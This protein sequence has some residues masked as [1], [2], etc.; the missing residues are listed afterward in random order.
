MM[1]KR[2][3]WT[4]AIV[5]ALPLLA[6]GFDRFHNIR[7]VGSTDLE[8]AFAITDAATGDPLPGAKVEVQSEGGFYEERDRQE[9]VLTAGADGLAR[10]ACRRS[11]CFGTQSGLW[12]T[13]TFAVHLPW[14]RFRPVADGYEPAEWTDLDVPE[15][16]RQAKKT[17]S[18]AKLVVPIILHKSHADRGDAPDRPRETR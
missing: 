17:G 8:V 13:D 15:Y 7:W 16:A 2:W 12:L 9:F 10:K 1:T 14:W 4:L 5:F 3:L 6:W 11:M 18:G